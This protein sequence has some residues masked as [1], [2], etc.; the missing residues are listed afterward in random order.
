MVLTRMSVGPAWLVLQWR[1]PC[2]S[3]PLTTPY[4]LWTTCL[5]VCRERGRKGVRS[6]ASVYTNHWVQMCACVRVRLCVCVRVPHTPALCA[7]TYQAVGCC[8]WTCSAHMVACRCYATCVCACVCVCGCMCVCACIFVCACVCLG[9]EYTSRGRPPQGIHDH[10][11]SPNIWPQW[12]KAQLTN[13]CWA[14]AVSPPAEASEGDII[15]LSAGLRPALCSYPVSWILLVPQTHTLVFLVCFLLRE[16]VWTFFCLWNGF[17]S[18]WIPSVCVCVLFL[19]QMDSL[20]WPASLFF[21]LVYQMQLLTC[22]IACFNCIY[23]PMTHRTQKVSIICDINL[24]V[25]NNNKNNNGLQYILK[26]MNE[27][28]EFMPAW[29]SLRTVSSGTEA[30]MAFLLDRD[31]TLNKWHLLTRCP[32]FFQNVF[33]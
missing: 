12:W 8:M 9:S 3:D 27:P 5:Q 1:R 25:Q 20:S 7:C 26:T 29:S 6:S 32:V 17:S 2:D 13:E 14:Q 21:Y 10:T 33:L 16:K 24:L 31:F 22:L 28:A 11:Q 15:M 4:G 18:I 19:K 23:N 30:L